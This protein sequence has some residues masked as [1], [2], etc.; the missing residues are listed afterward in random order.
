MIYLIG[1]FVV[2]IGVIQLYRLYR[3]SKRP[4][5][6]G[7]ILRLMDQHLKQDKS[8]KFRT[9]PHA[10]VLFRLNGKDYK[11]DILFKDKIKQIGDTVQLSYI[12]NNPES[13]EMYVPKAEFSMALII[14]LIGVVI[15]IISYFIMRLF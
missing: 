15:M 13:V 12:N 8:K 6:E 5:V 3:N 1:G 10:K 9:Q 11:V 7:K 14:T 2:L 4:K